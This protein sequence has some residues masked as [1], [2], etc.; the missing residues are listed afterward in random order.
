MGTSGINYSSQAPNNQPRREDLL[1]LD[2]QATDNWRFTGR[3]MN[4]KDDQEQAYGTTWAGAGSN[5]LDG[6]DTL[7]TTPART[8]CSRPPASSARRRRSN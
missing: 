8:T 2:F 7:F 1:R 4:K 3:Y 6:M 5:N